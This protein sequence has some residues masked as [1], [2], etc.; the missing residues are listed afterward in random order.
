M[1]TLI[2][3]TFSIYFKEKKMKEYEYEKWIAIAH[4]CNTTKEIDYILQKKP[5]I[6]K[7]I[8]NIYFLS[9]SWCNDSYDIRRSCA[10]WHYEK[11]ALVSD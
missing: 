1:Y 6:G 10:A 4:V 11:L 3:K 2:E 8:K 9:F 5:V 7:T